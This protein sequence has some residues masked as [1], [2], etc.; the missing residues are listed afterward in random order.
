M[1]DRPRLSFAEAPIRTTV[2]PTPVSPPSAIGVTAWRG[3]GGRDALEAWRANVG[4]PVSVDHGPPASRTPVTELP[5]TV[6]TVSGG[7]SR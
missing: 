1:A 6:T 5:R 7:D 4:E 3:A 2:E